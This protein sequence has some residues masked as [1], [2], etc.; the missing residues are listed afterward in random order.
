MASI[1][2]LP[3][4]EI[5]KICAGEVV[6]RPASVVKELIENSLDAGATR[7]GIAIEDGGKRMIS[8]MDNGCGIN[9][10]ELESALS[11][12]CTSKIRSADELYVKHSLGFRG[13]ALYS[14]ASISKL[15]IASR[16]AE[17]QAG[18]EIAVE[19]G[20]VVEKR[21]IALNKG[22]SIEVREL[23]LNTPVRR[24]FLRAK[25]T[26]VNF[27]TSMVLDYSLCYPEIAWRL[28]SDGKESFATRGDGDLTPILKRVFDAEIAQSIIK[29]DYRHS[30]D[31]QQG[32][33]VGS[34]AAGISISGV[35]AHP[36]YY[37]SNRIG[38][39]FFVNRRPVRNRIFYRAV[40]DACREYMSAG[41][42][43]L[44]VLML[45][46]PPSDIDV[47]IHPA[48]Q[49]VSFSEPQQIYALITIGVKRAISV[50]AAE[51]QATL[52]RDL[53]SDEMPPSPVNGIDDR[54]RPDESDDRED[55]VK[56]A[57]T[58]T[59]DNKI[60]GP[61][62]DKEISPE[63]RNTRSIP[64]YTESK[65]LPKPKRPVLSIAEFASEADDKALISA[66]TVGEITPEDLSDS[67]IMGQIGRTFIVFIKNDALYLLDQHSAHER[68]VFEGIYRNAI[69][70]ESSPPRQ[71]L[72]FPILLSLRP[73]QVDGIKMYIPVMNR[74]GF[75][76]EVFGEDTLLLREVP[77]SIAERIN[78]EVFRSIIE[79]FLVTG[80]EKSYNEMVK[81]V[82]ATTACK[83]AIKA[84]DEL[85]EAEMRWL[86]KSLTRLESSF[87]CPH[88]RPTLVKLGVR[89]VGKLFQRA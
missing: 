20:E 33:D 34:F 78:I 77:A 14:I 46:I 64:L 19:A 60:A 42:H 57:V 22:T 47:N 82:A 37:R 36:Q 28:E 40:D 49:E 15:K 7:I 52:A 54:A 67:Q 58:S 4:S 69:N 17:D 9:P 63:Q 10:N 56:E 51:Q 48:K 79:G 8:V 32:T 83:C 85:S 1:L 2:K 87:T 3:Q 41:K 65:T 68:I 89:D 25:G 11:A 71:G 70:R 43:A 75:Q 50:A 23:F 86:V 29:V 61:H 53:A 21:I 66:E 35:V 81:H 88:G 76:I 18:A 27:I 62:I 74:L 84:G 45:D 73:D 80:T 31:L 13:E 5:D 6:E 59:P 44:C 30:S 12:H 38:Q 26:E 72:V 39:H 55:Y 24:K 16:R